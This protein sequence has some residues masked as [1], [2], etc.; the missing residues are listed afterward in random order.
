MKIQIRVFQYLRNLYINTQI[1]PCS[2]GYPFCVSLG[3]FFILKL[4]TGFSIPVLA[5]PDSPE[6]ATDDFFDD[7]WFLVV[8][9]IRIRRPFHGYGSS[10]MLH[11]SLRTV[12]IMGAHTVPA[13]KDILRPD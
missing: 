4:N 3:L 8:L 5:L 7:L 11:T 2:V 9:R 6:N 10:K 13:Y 1:Q 12:R